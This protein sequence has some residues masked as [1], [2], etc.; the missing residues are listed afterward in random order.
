[1]HKIKRVLGFD[2][3]GNIELDKRS[4]TK[5]DLIAEG[6]TNDSVNFYTY[7]GSPQVMQD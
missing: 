3:N 2:K 4:L 5:E 1:L 6:D 7:I